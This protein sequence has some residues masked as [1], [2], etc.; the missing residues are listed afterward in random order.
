VAECQNLDSKIGLWPTSNE[1]EVE[2]KADER[3]QQVEDHRLG[4]SQGA[5]GE[6]AVITPLEVT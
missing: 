3:V 4:C 2:D 1:Q 5:G 6:A